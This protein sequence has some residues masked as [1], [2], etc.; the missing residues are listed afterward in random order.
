MGT[1]KAVERSVAVASDDVRDRVT[2]LDWAALITEL[3]THG[4]AVIPSLLT[5]EEC[6]AVAEMYPDDGRFRSR[7]VMSRHGFGR[8]EYKYFAYPSPPIVGSLRAA[9]YPHLAPVANRWYETMGIDVQFPADHAAF[10]ERCHAAGQAR[11]TPLL[12]RYGPGDFNCL[13]Q[14]VYGEHV[15][16]LQVAFLL[17]RPGA[18][19]TGGEFVLTE[20]R[21]R[22]QSRAEVVPLRQGDGVVFPVRE[23][24][25]QGTR[26]AYRVNLKHGVSRVCSGSRHT[27]GIIFHDAT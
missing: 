15:F 3:D 2:A 5:A 1:T 17:S 16:P 25:V 9:L 7:V 8:G 27:L 24:P 6:M 11:P 19:F 13:H 18:D 26:G 23:R 20:Q 22:M 12:L 10:V 14:D 4:C 21:P